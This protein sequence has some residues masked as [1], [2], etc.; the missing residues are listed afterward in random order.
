MGLGGTVRCDIDCSGY[1]QSMPSQSVIDIITILTVALSI[2]VFHS[3]PS[4]HGSFF[5]LVTVR[6]KHTDDVYDDETVDKDVLI[7]LINFKSSL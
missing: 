6:Q 1:A 7:F 4:T 5:L 2:Q 3:R